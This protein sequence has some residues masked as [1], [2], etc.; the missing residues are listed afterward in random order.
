[1]PVKY[2]GRKITTDEIVIK[3]QTTSEVLKNSFPSVANDCFLAKMEIERLVKEN[4]QLKENNPCP[5]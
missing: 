4:K 3:L 1:M 2:F 5:T